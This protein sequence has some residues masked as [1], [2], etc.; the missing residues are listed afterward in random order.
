MLSKFLLLSVFL[1]GCGNNVQI[2][3]NK[4]ESVAPLSSSE[5]AKYEKLGVLTTG[6]PSRIQYQGQQYPVSE[7]SSKATQD[8]INS[9]GRGT[10]VQVIFTGA[11]QNSQMVIE[12]IKRQN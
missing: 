1:Y 6:S 7:Y 12:T 8:F 3:N 10:Q 4:L 5:L 11:S 2:K 9:F